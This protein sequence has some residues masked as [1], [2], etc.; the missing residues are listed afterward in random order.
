[1]A[2][3]A[4]LRLGKLG[5][6]ADDLLQL[7]LLRLEPAKWDLS[8]A[9]TLALAARKRQLGNKHFQTGGL[10]K[11]VLRYSDALALV[12]FDDNFELDSD[13]EEDDSHGCSRVHGERVELKDVHAERERC[14]S[15]LAAVALNKGQTAKAVKYCERALALNE[16]NAKVWF[17]KGRAELA[18]GRMDAACESLREA[19]GLAPKDAEAQQLLRDCLQQSK[20]ARQEQR[21]REKEFARAGVGTNAD[22]EPTHAVDALWAGGAR[23]REAHKGSSGYSAAK[24]AASG[25]QQDKA[26]R[27]AEIEYNR[28]QLLYHME[29]NKVRSEEQES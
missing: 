5:V 17:R 28:R 20:Q 3:G 10:E 13:E 4:K 23:E 1:M 22:D 15:N 18:E 24:V 26:E 25:K 6:T 16:A 11:A 27:D 2:D 9:E 14:L 8:G 12:E 7:Q 19:V 29:K 21:S